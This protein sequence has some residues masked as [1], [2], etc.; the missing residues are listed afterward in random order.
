[1]TNHEEP[2]L[3]ICHDICHAAADRGWVHGGTV[4]GLGL[5]D[6]PYR[7]RKGHG[8]GEL[9][10]E[11][12]AKAIDECRF[13]ILIPTSAA[14]WDRLAQCAATLAQHARLE[15]ESP[16]LII[17]ARDLAPSSDG[18]RTRLPLRQRALVGLDCSDEEQ[19][20]EVV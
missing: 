15:G 3:H 10:L 19:G 4:R 5:A 7:A 14:R 18:K 9:H 13:T 16:R 17:V 6:G 1:M 2:L 12:I 11:A 8:L 20:P